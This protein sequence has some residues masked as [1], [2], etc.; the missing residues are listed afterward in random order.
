M[1]DVGIKQLADQLGI[2][3]ASV[4]RALNNPS[5][6]SDS[7]RE[8]V[9]AAAEKA[10]YS[11]NKLGAG[12]RTSKTGNIIAIIPDLS[13]TF[14]SGVIKSLENVAAEH[15]YSILFGNTKGK[16]DLEIAYGEMVRSKQADGII[17]FSHRMP[18]TDE[19]LK[20][21]NFQLPPFVNS[22][23]PVGIPGIPLVTID[24]EEA[25]RLATDHL[26]ELGHTEI[27]VITGASD[28]PSSRLRL[29]GYRKA[30]K[31]AGIEYQDRL[32]TLG[33]YT[34]SAGVTGT[35]DILQLK[36]RPTAIIC[37]CDETALGCLSTL[38]SNNFKVPEDI[39]VVGFDDI[40]FA[41]YFSPA[42]TT[43]AQPVADIGRRCFELLY[44]QINGEKIPTQGEYL[45]HKLIVR[46]STAKV[47]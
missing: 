19:V 33:N 18:F 40:R 5:R 34:L 46:D 24:N 32:V 39:S 37:F 16:R 30:L 8:R 22:C 31:A 9:C 1:S 15:G 12:L 44:A 3:I 11:P 26:L 14:N 20:N 43:V 35:K 42:L 10:N 7:M 17:S 28:S 38:K 13:D 25:G 45:P 36:N 29:D 41:Q 4:S 6:V 27:A 47:T 23:E 2:S 21:P